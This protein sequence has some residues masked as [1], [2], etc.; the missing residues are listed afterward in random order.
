[1]FAFRVF[2]EKNQVFLK[3]RAGPIFQNCSM[4]ENDF[5]VYSRIAE[6]RLMSRIMASK[7]DREPQSAISGSWRLRRSTSAWCHVCKKPVGL[8]SFS[9]AAAAFNTDLQDIGFLADRGELHRLHNRYAEL[10]TAGT[11]CSNVLTVGKRASLP[12]TNCIPPGD[13]PAAL[14][15]L[16]CP[17]PFSPS[18]FGRRS[19]RGRS[20]VPFSQHSQSEAGNTVGQI[21]FPISRIFGILCEQCRRS[22]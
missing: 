19:R 11:R 2:S 22:R 15:S 10:M 18:E 4:D 9:A 12:W 21:L 14:P 20:A 5:T 7:P 13:R 16:P 6:E 17:E 1:L 3:S 8:L